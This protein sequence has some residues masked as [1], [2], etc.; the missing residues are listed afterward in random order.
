MTFKNVL[1][2]VNLYKAWWRRNCLILPEHMSSLPAMCGVRVA[3]SLVFCADHFCPCILFLVAIVLFVLRFTVSDYPPLV[4]S[5]IYV[6]SIL[7]LVVTAELQKLL[8]V[9]SAWVIDCCEQLSHLYHCKNVLT[10]SLWWSV[11]TRSTLFVLT[12]WYCTCIAG[13]RQIFI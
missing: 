1:R 9:T 10:R 7:S 8:N 13:K 6:R 3:R 2:N 5:N 12:L 4:S 11:S